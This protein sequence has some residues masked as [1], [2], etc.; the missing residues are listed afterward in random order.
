MQNNAKNISIQ[1]FCLEFNYNYYPY[2][3]YKEDVNFQ[4]WF[5]LL[6]EMLVELPKP[7]NVY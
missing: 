7:I 4:S 1:Y 5:K 3:W 2:F 6:D